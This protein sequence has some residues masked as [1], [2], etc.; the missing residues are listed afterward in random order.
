MRDT[1]LSG[2]WENGQHVLPLRVYY[3]DTDAGGVVYHSRFLD[4]AERGRTEM[5][6]SL[7]I[8][9]PP[10]P[11]ELSY[12]VRACELDYK[13][14]ARLDDLLLI[15]SKVVSLGGASFRIGQ[16]VCR[17]EVTLVKIAITLVCVRELGHPI[18][19]P[20]RL[21]ERMS[22]LLSDEAKE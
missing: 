21:R 2:W 1:S 17:G 7:E 20:E 13:H 9:W 14:S 15:R 18:R 16:E 6:R 22:A 11:G 8:D 3:A 4:F 5:I 19:M 12:V 10:A